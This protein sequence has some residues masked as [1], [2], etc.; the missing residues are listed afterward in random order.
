MYAGK[1][2]QKYSKGDKETVCF[3]H[4]TYAFYSESTLCSC[5]NVKELLAQNTR[6]I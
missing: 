2:T 1:R 6:D 5:V 4:V 3:Y